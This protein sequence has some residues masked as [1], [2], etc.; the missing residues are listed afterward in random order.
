MHKIFFSLCS[1]ISID[2]SLYFDTKLKDF[3]NF[4]IFLV[5]QNAVLQLFELMFSLRLDRREPF[6]FTLD[7][8]DLGL[9][10]VKKNGF[11]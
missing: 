7:N 11:R 2:W 4:V 6:F 3:G 8:Q 1:A 5:Q 10:S 9:S